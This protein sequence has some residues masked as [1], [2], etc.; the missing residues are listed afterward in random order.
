MFGI[1]R[2]SFWRAVGLIGC[3][4]WQ[5]GGR[6]LFPAVNGTAELTGVTESSRPL[7]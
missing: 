7:F 5:Y 4:D 1:V 3:K 6:S 2:T